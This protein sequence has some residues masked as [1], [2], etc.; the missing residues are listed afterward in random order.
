MS[1]RENRVEW[2]AFINALK[3]EVK[4]AL[5]CTEPVS[6][7]LACAVAAQQLPGAI[8]R[9]EVAVSP[10]LMKN[11]MGVTIPGTG[12]TGLPIAAALGAIAGDPQ[13]KLEVLKK[14]TKR[15]INAARA[16]LEVGAVRVSLQEPCDEIIFVRAKVY[17]GDQHATVTI[18]G[19][20]TNVVAIEKMG[21][22]L[23]IK[24]ENNT[25][26]DTI[27]PLDRVASSSLRD[28]YNF[29]CDI[30]RKSSILFSTQDR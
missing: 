21:Q 9:I 6:V 3:Q 26:E 22:S 4:P 8:V 17:A 5:G 27:N 24:P 18:V 30:P 12:M 1:H 29:I 2:N 10:N 19:D 16:L 11:G 13:A 15:E 20:H 23:F 7:A 14:A 25:C 28:I